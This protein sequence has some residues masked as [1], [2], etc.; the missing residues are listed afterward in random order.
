[1]GSDL[2]KVKVLEKSDRTVKLRVEVVHPDSNYLPDGLVFA[3]MVLHEGARG[4]DSDLEKEVSFDDTMDRGWLELYTKGF[5]ESAT[6]NIESGSSDGQEPK[7]W[8][9]GTLTVT[10]T[11]P[12][13]ISHLHPG[14]EFDSRAWD[15][16]SSLE[17]CA[18][19]RPGQVDPNAK[20]PE[21]FISL[22]G[23]LWQDSG[24]PAAVRAPAYSASGY[25]APN[26]KKGSFTAADLK[27]LDGEVVMYQG[28]YDSSLG[29][30]ILSLQGEQIRIFTASD[31]SYGSSGMTPFE[32]S[33]GKAELIPGKR[34]GS[35]LKLS[36]MLGNLQPK[37][38]GATVNG[39]SADFRIAVPPGHTGLD[40]LSD[41][42]L[43]GGGLQ[44]LLAPLTPKEDTGAQKLLNPSPLSWTIEREV[45]R[46]FPAEERQITTWTNNKSVP[47]GDSLPDHGS[48]ARRLGR[49]F[50]AKGEVISRASSASVDV[51][52]MTEAQ[53]REV[54]V[55][56]WPEMVIRV[57][58]HHAAYLQHLAQPFEPVQLSWLAEAE[59]WE[60]APATPATASGGFG[61]KTAPP[62]QS[63]SSMSAPAP[64]ASGNKTLKIVGIVLGSLFGL[65]VLCTILS[66][67][68]KH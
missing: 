39:D 33:I 3:L 52:S 48:I 9:K 35:R 43:I 36:R 1:M 8:I 46:V 61:K 45:L 59:A 5:I 64:T 17:D 23:S 11:D 53:Q 54:L 26:L 13:W 28:P 30:G 38:V 21:P 4:R 57:T 65:C 7:D 63:T 20:M 55:K 10:V 44:L 12:A 51:D 56:P 66:S 47:I 49:G 19:I 37:I 32:G 42:Q 31:G 14:A 25:R 58:P 6:T 67:L 15:A 40:E 27:D 34:L 2:Y 41:D 62:V 29:V 68:G 16:A 24:L 22:P 60:G 50:I 18:P